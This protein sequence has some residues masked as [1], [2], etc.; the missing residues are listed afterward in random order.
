MYIKFSRTRD[1]KEPKRGH[2]PDAGLDFF[3]P[4]DYE[5]VIIEAGKSVLIDSGIKIEIPVGFCGMFINKSSVASK[6]HL[7]V[8]AAI[9]D[10]FYS[11]TI[12]IDLH[13]ISD[14]DVTLEPGM[15]IVQM[16][17]IPIIT[18]QL[19]EEKDDNRL[20]ENAKKMCDGF[21]DQ[22]GFGSTGNK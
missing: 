11:N 10:P 20:Y 2:V 21:R 4:N 17:L 6:L 22:G 13:N 9:I 3:V 15:K 5:N 16:I 12:K 14:R 7:V 19:I 8:G 1:V 18:P